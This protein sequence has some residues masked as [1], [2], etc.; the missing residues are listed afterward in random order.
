MRLISAAFCVMLLASPV[1]AAETKPVVVTPVAAELATASGQPIILPQHD[2]QVIV[3]TYDI[4]AGAVLP[5]HKHPF[6]RYAYVLTGTL[7]VT[8]T[9][10]G[11][12]DVYKP[13]DFIIEAIGQWHK[14]ATIGDEPV[15]L[16]VIDQVEKDQSNTVMRQ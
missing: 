2:A 10:T 6:P 14:A 16:L 7:R 9:D 13:G 3:S 5:E 15:K 1:Q 11:T 8:N 12:S 4:A